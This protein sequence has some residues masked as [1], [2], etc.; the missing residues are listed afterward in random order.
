MESSVVFELLSGG[1]GLPAAIE[2]L[3]QF[4]SQHFF[5]EDFVDSSEGEPP[6]GADHFGLQLIL[7]QLVIDQG[8]QVAGDLQIGG[9][10]TQLA[11][12]GG[13]QQGLHGIADG[14]GVV[15]NQGLHG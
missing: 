11:C 10:I 9:F 8:I 1:C 15:S 3:E 5:A 12:L 7:V 2:I 6:I 4:L 13:Q 14:D